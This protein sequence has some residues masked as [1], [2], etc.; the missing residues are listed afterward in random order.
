MYFSPF[1]RERGVLVK[2]QMFS[3]FGHTLA[4]MEEI[5]RLAGPSSQVPFCCSFLGD[6]L[7]GR[8]FLNTRAMAEG[9]SAWA[10]SNCFGICAE[11]SAWKRHQVFLSIQ[12]W[13]GLNSQISMIWQMSNSLFV[14]SAICWF[15]NRKDS[16]RL[17]QVASSFRDCGRNRWLEKSWR[18]SRIARL[19]TS[20]SPFHS[21][22]PF[23]KK[24]VTSFF[25][26]I[27]FY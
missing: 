18:L 24:I 20:A 5:G 14:N 10:K 19:P 1:A 21:P 9:P 16:Q 2:K 27:D 12:S 15:E 22:R 13:N 8:V 23:R 4:I 17:R 7:F 11:I 3:L 26:K 6:W 25:S